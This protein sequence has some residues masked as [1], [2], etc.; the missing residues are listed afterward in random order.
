MAAFG[1]S[2]I[3]GVAVRMTTT[4]AELAKQINAF[5]GL[6]GNEY[7]S[8][9][10]RGYMTRASGVLVATNLS[11]LESARDNFYSYQ[12]GVARDLADTMGK[13]WNNV[14]LQNFD[15][16]QWSTDGTRWV[17]PYQALFLHLT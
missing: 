1:G 4:K 2:N 8:G 10:S 13:T 3:F 5:F 6:D 11:D 12:D 16:G 7:R 15:P 14:L 17:Q 9:G